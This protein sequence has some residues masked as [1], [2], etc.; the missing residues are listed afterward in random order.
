MSQQGTSRDNI[1][2]GARWKAQGPV[3]YKYRPLLQPNV[4][5]QKA[6]VSD[7]GRLLSPLHTPGPCDWEPGKG[8]AGKLSQPSYHIRCVLQHTFAQGQYICW[9]VE[10]LAQVLMR[11][12]TLLLCLPF[13]SSFPLFILA[14][15]F[16][17]GSQEL[18][19]RRTLFTIALVMFVT[20]KTIAGEAGSPRMGW[21]G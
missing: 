11:P 21:T 12:L 16:H 14:P 20:F 9:R 19:S 6:P 17:D 4:A 8:N 18:R 10:T 2:T 1:G 5:P 15:S 3:G 7:R 13:L